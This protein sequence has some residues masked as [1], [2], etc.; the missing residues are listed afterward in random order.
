MRASGPT[1][2]PDSDRARRIG[3]RADLQPS[4]GSIENPKPALPSVNVEHLIP[5]VVSTEARITPFNMPRFPRRSEVEPRDIE[6]I[7]Q[8]LTLVFLTF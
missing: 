3:T 7:L 6:V 2:R 1:L 5:D 4:A 8:R